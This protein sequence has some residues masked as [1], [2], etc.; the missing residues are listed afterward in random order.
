VFLV[1]EEYKLLQTETFQKSNAPYLGN[2]LDNFSY[3][4]F[5][6]E[7]SRRL[8]AL[9]IWFTLLAYGKDGYQSIVEQSA[10]MARLFGEYIKKSNGFENLA[11]VRLNNVC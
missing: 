6:P 3:L 10:E 9:P 8:K 5:L 1:K 4:N 2:P 7:N 11:P